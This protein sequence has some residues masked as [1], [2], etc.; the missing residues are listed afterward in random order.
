[1]PERRRGQ[2]RVRPV[3]VRD[4][5]RSRGSRSKGALGALLDRPDGAA[6]PARLAERADR[7]RQHSAGADG[8]RSLALW[9][10]GQTINLMTLG[11]LALAIGILVDK[12]TVEIENIHTH[13]ARRASASRAR[14]SDSGGEVAAAAAD[15]HAVHPG[16]VRAVVLHAWAR[17]ARCSCRCRWPSGFAMVASY[18]LSS[19]FVPSSVRLAAAGPSDRGASARRP[20]R[21]S[22]VR[23][24]PGALT[25][26]LVERVVRCALARRSAAISPLATL[27]IVVVGGAPRHGDLPEGRHRPAPGAPA[28]AEPGTRVDGTEQSRCSALDLIKQEV[29]PRQRRASRSRFV[30]VH[31]PNYPINLI[32]LWNGGPEEGVLQVQL[33]AGAERSTS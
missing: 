13:L 31:A 29:G 32:Y 9:L 5:A 21:R 25:A 2:L 12:S 14:S 23:A 3:A 30:G 11:G 6:L 10:T 20:G 28:R 26:R 22:A 27:V 19:T 17:R 8:L 4:R 1:M 24:V 7:R 15:R 33:K 16:G 18:L